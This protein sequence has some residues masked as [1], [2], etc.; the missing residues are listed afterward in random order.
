MTAVDPA[1]LLSRLRMR[2]KQSLRRRDGWRVSARFG[3]DELDPTGQE[4]SIFVLGP[5]D[6]QHTTPLVVP[7]LQLSARGSW[8]FKNDVPGNGLVRVRLRQGRTGLWRIRARCRGTGILDPFIPETAFSIILRIGPDAFV[9]DQR[10]EP[11]LR[12]VH[13]TVEWD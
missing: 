8:L 3:A 9:L 2:L 10:D 13:G 7:G 5:G 6:V 11:Q 4:V 12:G 1:P